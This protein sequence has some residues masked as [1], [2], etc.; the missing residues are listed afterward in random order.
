M[1]L[2]AAGW[3]DRD[4]AL[5]NDE[6]ATRMVYADLVE[7]R[8]QLAYASYL[9]VDPPPAP[10]IER[11]ENL[12]YEARTVLLDRGRR[13]SD[14]A[15]FAPMTPPR[16]ARL[17]NAG[18]MLSLHSAQLAL[19]VSGIVPVDTAGARIV[20]TFADGTYWVHA[21]DYG[22]ALING[23]YFSG[24]LERPLFDGDE[25]QIQQTTYVFRL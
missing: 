22:S 17:E 10:R 2:Y 14:I 12:F 24:D 19:K 15:R 18:K 5:L 9:R 1:L 20:M 6:P 4:A 13:R 3:E 11:V 16:P 7:Q 21:R 25:I 23:N 8:G